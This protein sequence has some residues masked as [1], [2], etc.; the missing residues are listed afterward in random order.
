M[1]EI[2]PGVRMATFTDVGPGDQITRMLAGTIEMTL[3]VERVDDKL[4]Y[5]KG[6]WMFDR[7]TGVEEDPDLG[8]G[9]ASG[10]TG[11]FLVPKGASDE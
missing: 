8:W 7:Q 1:S 6:G 2:T 3:V 4:I 10:V 9:V 5:A 11:S